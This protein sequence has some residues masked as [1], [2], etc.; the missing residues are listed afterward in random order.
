VNIRKALSKDADAITSVHVNAWRSA[1]AGLIPQNFLDKVTVEKRRAM[2]TQ[3]LDQIEAGDPSKMCSVA[4]DDN[5]L[6]LGFI[7]GDKIRDE[8]PNYDSELYAIYLEETVR[9]QG[10]GSRLTL[11]L[12][13]WLAAQGFKSMRLWVLEKNPSRNFYESIGGILVS[14]TKT[15]DFGGLELLEVSYGYDLKKLVK[16]L[17]ARFKS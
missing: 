6:M 12:A 9:Q 5:G 1:Y 15:V 14:D 4:E 3:N 10:I 8:H 13:G 17:K 2:W 16:V 11:E 7:S